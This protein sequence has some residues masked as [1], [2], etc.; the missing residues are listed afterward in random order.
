M[1]T[2]RLHAAETSPTGSSVC[3]PF[4]VPTDV[5]GYLDVLR[6][7]HQ[8][9]LLALG[10]AS[11]RL[12]GEHSELAR[13]AAIHG[14][15]TRQFFDAQRSL[16]RRRA[17][18]ASEV[19][20]IESEATSNSSAVVALAR[21]RP[22]AVGDHHAPRPSEPIPGVGRTAVMDR[23]QDVV[24]LMGEVDGVFAT[25]EPEGV[26]AQRQL[27]EL[28]DGWWTSEQQEAIAAVD[29]AHARAAVRQHAA[30]LEAGALITS[31]SGVEYPHRSGRLPSEM[32][33]VLDVAVAADL[34]GVLSALVAALQ[35]P[36][37]QSSEPGHGA[38]QPSEPPLADGV[39]L[40][41]ENIAAAGADEAFQQ[42]WAKQPDANPPA[43]RM[44]WWP[45]A[46]VM[47]PVGLVS[48]FLVLAAVRVG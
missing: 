27:G 44:R 24:A 33:A 42:F 1:E 15:L 36:H 9:L 16:L 29:D 26:V 28:L 12:G 19:A 8:R 31:P 18:A 39:I 46:A 23:S 14:R 6:R 10:E 30:L 2:T 3:V 32:S 4:Q 37:T 7:E 43:R 45:S 34:E 41:F 47:V 20:S 48:S 38:V 25:R 5:E 17:E 21:R 11:S 22:L 35:V 40:R 13:A